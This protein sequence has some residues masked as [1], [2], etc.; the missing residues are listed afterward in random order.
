MVETTSSAV[1]KLRSSDLPFARDASINAR[2]DIDLSPGGD[3]VPLSRL[4]EDTV[5]FIIVYD[6]DPFAPPHVLA[7]SSIH[8]G[9]FLST[10]I[11]LTYPSSALQKKEV[12][13]VTNLRLHHRYQIRIC[14]TIFP[15]I[16]RPWQKCLKVSLA[17]FH[18]L[19]SQPFDGIPVT[20]L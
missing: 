14:A 20:P 17:P 19:C 10:E 7:E 1:D 6:G 8:P 16:P 9:T 5:R 18:L 3:K 13:G 11:P 4:G 12:P 2:C 15:W